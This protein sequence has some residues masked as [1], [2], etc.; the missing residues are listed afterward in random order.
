MGTRLQNTAALP[1]VMTGIGE[2]VKATK[3]AGLPEEVSELVGIRVSQIN[4]CAVCLHLHLG[5]AEKLGI[6][7]ER[8]A[9]LAAWRDTPFFTDQE[10]AALDVAEHMTRLADRTGEAVPDDVWDAAAQHFD[11]RQLA[12]LVL[13]VGM[14]NMFNRLNTAVREVPG[15]QNW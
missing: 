15:Q 11:E 8:Q 6:S 4:G 14:I 2:L 5:A 1:G 3:S 7:Q 13:G 10:R 12:A 9:T